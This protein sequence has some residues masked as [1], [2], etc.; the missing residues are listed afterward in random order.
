MT[1]S[2]LIPT[3]FTVKS[4]KL[5][6]EIAET[7]ASSSVRIVLVHGI[8]L[9]SSITDLLFYS[10]RKLIDSLQTEAFKNS[11]AMILNKY[12]SGIASITIEIFNGH[13]MASFE[14]FIKGHGIDEACIPVNYTLKMKHAR[15]F[16]LMPF[17]LKAS[18]RT[19]QVD[20]MEYTPPT[21]TVEMDQLADLFFSNS[22]VAKS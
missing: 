16:D 11:C 6:R 10:K 7:Y 8:Q 19:K 22:S 12:S 3:D 1:R 20:L 18:I 15:S 2:I 13:N 9:S 21:D 14:N 4:L 17:L 5:V